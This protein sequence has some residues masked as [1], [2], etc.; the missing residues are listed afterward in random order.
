MKGCDSHETEV[1]IRLDDEVGYLA[2]YAETTDTQ[3]RTEHKNTT[4]RYGSA[5]IS[6]QQ[7]I[8][9]PFLDES[10]TG[11]KLIVIPAD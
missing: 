11:E 4:I 2:V 3:R 1:K 6:T 5:G 7:K 10:S 9:S 8:K